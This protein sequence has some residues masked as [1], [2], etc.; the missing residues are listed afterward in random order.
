MAKYDVNY[1][2]GHSGRIELFGKNSER[3]RKIEWL[4]G[5]ECPNCAA[6]TRAEKIERQ[7]IAAAGANL[8]AGLPP[9]T[10]SEKQI[11]WAETIRKFR[12][13]HI[14]QL[15][16]LSKPK[17]ETIP[18]AKLAVEILEGWRGETRAAWWID[19]RDTDLRNKLACEVKAKMQS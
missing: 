14:D 11:A 9:L 5:Q 17:A 7:N 3:Q 8:V 2:C 18:Q 10:G 1:N 13:D 4:S 19:N 16:T 12:I 6:Q 15:L